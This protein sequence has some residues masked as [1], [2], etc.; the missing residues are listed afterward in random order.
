MRWVQEEPKNQ[1][2]WT[3][4][5]PLVQ[6][7]IGASRSLEYLGRE[8]AASPATGSSKNHQ[9]EEAAILDEALKRPRS[10]SPEV[11]RVADRAAG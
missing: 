2:A 7:V 5:A 1:G 8:Q 9:A 4:V 10:A 6:G 3:F 11:H